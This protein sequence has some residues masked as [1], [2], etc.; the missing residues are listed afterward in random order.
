L[1]EWT[2]RIGVLSLERRM[3][4]VLKQFSSLWKKQASL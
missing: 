3:S 2:A 1:P 4:H